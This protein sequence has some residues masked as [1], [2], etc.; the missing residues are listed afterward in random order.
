MKQE[1]LALLLKKTMDRTLAAA[2]GVVALP[3]LAAAAVA[4]RGTMGAPVFFTQERP[5]LRGKTFRIYKLRTMGDA[6][7]KYGRPIPDEQRVTRVGRVL[8]SL[9]IDELPQLWNVLRGELSLVGP[10]PLLVRY[11]PLYTPEQARRHDV[12]PGI[13]GW[14]QV[15]GR[16]AL[17]WEDKFALDVWYVDHWSPLLDLQI[18]ARTAIAVV[19]REGISPKDE[20]I[21]PEFKGSP[22]V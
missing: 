12:M 8:R 7:D 6:V 4:V 19:R 17:T 10:R 21:M 3:V 18:L 5:G 13:T 2:L 9:S 11:L 1:G 22:R 15:N 16:N 14:T 20:L